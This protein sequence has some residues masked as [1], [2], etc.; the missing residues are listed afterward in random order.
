MSSLRTELEKVLGENPCYVPCFHF[1]QPLKKLDRSPTTMA[2]FL[3]SQ[4]IGHVG[5]FLFVYPFNPQL[6]DIYLETSLFIL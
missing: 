6:R 4:L 5:L 3:S 2:F 1:R